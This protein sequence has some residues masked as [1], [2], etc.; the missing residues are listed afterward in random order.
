MEFST[1]QVDNLQVNCMD[2]LAVDLV[3]GKGMIVQLPTQLVT[4]AIECGTDRAFVWFSLK[5]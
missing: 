4:T 3:T 5:I 2:A 1:F